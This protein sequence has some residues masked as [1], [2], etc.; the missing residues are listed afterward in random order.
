MEGVQFL[1]QAGTIF[2]NAKKYCSPHMQI[3][4]GNTSYQHRKTRLLFAKALASRRRKLFPVVRD[5][6]NEWHALYKPQDEIIRIIGYQWSPKSHQIKEFLSGNLIPYSW[7]DIDMN[8]EAQQYLASA[9]VSVA[10][11]PVVLLKDGTVHKDPPLHDLASH[12]GLHQKATRPCM[13]S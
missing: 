4:S 2:P 9:K 12:I 7:L 6:L 1:E 8:I 5:L 10:E 13:M 3:S 11:L